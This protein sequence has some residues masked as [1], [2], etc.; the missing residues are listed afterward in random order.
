MLLPWESRDRNL[1]E[2]RIWQRPALPL[3]NQKTLSSHVHPALVLFIG[4]MGVAI[5]VLL[6]VFRYQYCEMRVSLW[7]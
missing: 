1:A 3:T 5:S 4:K 2:T 6:S 7:E